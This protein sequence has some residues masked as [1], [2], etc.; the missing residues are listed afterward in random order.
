MNK[1]DRILWRINGVLFLGLLIFGL[2]PFV[3][4][5]LPLNNRGPFEREGAII[6]ETKGTHEKELLRLEWPSRIAGT[7]ILRMPLSSQG[8]SK[9]SSFSGD[10]YGSQIRNFLFVDHSDLSSWWLFKGF[11]YSIIKPHDLLAELEGKEKRVISTIFEVA[12]SDT[13]GDH[14]VTTGDRISAFFTGADGRKTVEIVR[15]ADRIVSLDQVT[16]T[17]VLITYQSGPAVTAAVFSVKDGAKMR[18]API[19][20]IKE[21][22]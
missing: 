19:A 21:N 4:E 22:K 6:N 20:P 9:I 15:S 13:N 2:L 1:F 7:S 16:D 3:W 14:R 17:E 12:T 18:E 8:S 11:Q 10:G 5:L